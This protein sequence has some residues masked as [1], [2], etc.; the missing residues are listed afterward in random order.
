MKTISV[1]DLKARLSESLRVVKAGER[2]L[3]T[4][5]GRPIAVLA[6][7]GAEADDPLARLEAAGLVRV[8]TR[9]LPRGFWDMPRPRDPEG[10][11]L[12]G[13]LNEREEGW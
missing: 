1:S 4:E 6:P 5:R 2:L 12:R 11:V 13:L 8:G 3:V 9:R 10:K 7:A